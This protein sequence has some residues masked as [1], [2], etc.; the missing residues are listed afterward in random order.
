MDE[1][2]CGDVNGAIDNF[3][4]YFEHLVEHSLFFG[5]WYGGF[6]LNDD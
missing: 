2:F 6:F 5:Q 4:V 3:G 1:V